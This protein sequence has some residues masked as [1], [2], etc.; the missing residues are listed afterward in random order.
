MSVWDAVIIGGG[1]GAWALFVVWMLL[2]VD[3]PIAEQPE[4]SDR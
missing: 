4:G 3:P 2:Y 1:L